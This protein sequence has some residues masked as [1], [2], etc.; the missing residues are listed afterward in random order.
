LRNDPVL[1]VW[2]EDR[3]FN[4]DVLTS[5]HVT[6]VLHPLANGLVNVSV[7]VSDKKARVVGPLHGSTI[8]SKY[9]LGKLLMLTAVNC[10]REIQTVQ[11]GISQSFA[12]RQRF[13]SDIIRRY[14]SADS[15]ASLF[16]QSLFVQTVTRPA[17]ANAPPGDAPT[18]LFNSS[19]GGTPDVIGTN[20][21]PPV[22]VLPPSSLPP[23]IASPT[24]HHISAG[25]SLPGMSSPRQFQMPSARAPPPPEQHMRTHSSQSDSNP[26]SPQFCL[27][28]NP[29]TPP[30]DDSLGS[31]SPIRS[32]S[33]LLHRHAAGEEARPASGSFQV[34]RPHPPPGIP[35][36]MTPM[37]QAMQLQ[38]MQSQQK[39]GPPQQHGAQKWS[40][41]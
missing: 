17:P 14:R 6:F 23:S 13:L 34:V 31:R 41:L 18:R 39:P 22:A 3:N 4:P 25:I 15:R 21:P 30:D 19:P 11:L 2:S 32:S 33:S 28:S 37:Q 35:G 38:Q 7:R 1:I 29:S 5:H 20:L 12:I 24:S 40:Y 8:V 26:G 36:V 27:G 9:V 16:Y 10:Y